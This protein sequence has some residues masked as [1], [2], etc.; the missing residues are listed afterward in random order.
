M[1]SKVIAA[2][3]S[4]N[5]DLGKCNM[6]ERIRIGIVPYMNA[7]P[8]IY[9]LECHKDSIELLFEVP[10]L[11]PGMLNNDRIDVA[12][13]PSIEYFRN[14]CFAIIPHIAIASHGAVES[15]KIFSKVPI[16]NIQT[17]ALDTSSLTSRALTR[18]ILHGQYHLTPGYT[19][20]NEQYNIAETR[21]DAVL[22]IGDNAIKAADNG[23]VTLDLGQAWY[24]Y[25]RLPFV[26]AVWVVK[27]GRKIPGLNEL[28]LNSKKMGIQHIKEIAVSEAKRLN[29]SFDTCLHYLTNAIQYDLEK[30]EIQ[31]LKKFYQCAVAIELAPKGERVIFN[32]T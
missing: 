15:V 27:R 6:T 22:I 29:I 12:L 11:L 13:I 17:A 31:G 5:K 26:Y 9:G 2:S 30:E 4:K 32:D 25:T 7:K 1:K 24:E 20:F 18:I 8:L 28:L 3:L 23:Y 14:G 19:Q 21:A 16:A 10:S